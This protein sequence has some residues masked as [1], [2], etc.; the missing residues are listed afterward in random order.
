MSLA[1][2]AS[3]VSLTLLST[4]CIALLLIDVHY[5]RQL[6]VHSYTIMTVHSGLVFKVVSVY[7]IIWYQNVPCASCVSLVE[8]STAPTKAYS[9]EHTV[10]HIGLICLQLCMCVSVRASLHACVYA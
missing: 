2:C 1:T 10:I 3:S 5:Y 4:N 9:I 8:I 6:V 7:I